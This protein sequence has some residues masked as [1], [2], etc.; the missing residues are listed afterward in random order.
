[1]T[2]AASGFKRLSSGIY[3]NLTW[4][5]TNKR[6]ILWR[7]FQYERILIGFS[8]LFDIW[9]FSLLIPH[10][11]IGISHLQ[12]RFFIKGPPYYLHAHG[13]GINRTTRHTY[14]RKPCEI[15]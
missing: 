12:N 6:P 11:L 9:H 3:M 14:T 13:E 8:S 10:L 5:Y 1:M 4:S 15:E 2:E 7:P